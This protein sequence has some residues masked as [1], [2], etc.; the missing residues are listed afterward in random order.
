[1]TITTTISADEVMPTAAADEKVSAGDCSNDL[2]ATSLIVADEQAVVVL[3]LR[4]SR[5][6]LQFGDDGAG[7]TPDLTGLSVAE[8]RRLSPWPSA[9]AERRIVPLMTTRN[10]DMPSAW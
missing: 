10:K 8:L 3:T 4:R 1:M 2:S 9:P 7:I 5:R 6:H